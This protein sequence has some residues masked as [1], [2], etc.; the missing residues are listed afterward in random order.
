MEGRWRMIGEPCKHVRVLVRH[1]SAT[2]PRPRSTAEKLAH[3]AM[4]GGAKVVYRVRSAKRQNRRKSSRFFCPNLAI[5]AMQSA[6]AAPRRHNSR[7]S[8]S[9]Y[10]TL[11]LCR[12]S[13]WSLEYGKSNGS[14]KRASSDLP[15]GSIA[16]YP[17]VFR[18]PDRSRPNDPCHSLNYPITLC[19]AAD[20]LDCEDAAMLLFQAYAFLDETASLG[21]K[22]ATIRS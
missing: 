16:V 20:G 11:P 19:A 2:P 14:S 18:D 17:I 6:Q 3:R 10:S 13:G 9:E 8:S 1:P 5:S 12:G 7:I 22:L 15:S 21:G 4:P